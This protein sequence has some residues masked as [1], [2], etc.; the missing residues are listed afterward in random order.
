M[1]TLLLSFCRFHF[2][3]RGFSLF[4]ILGL[5]LALFP[6]QLHSWC[7]TYTSYSYI[8]PSTYWQYVSGSISPNGAYSYCFY[9][10]YG[11]TY[12][13]TFCS[14]SG[15]SATFDTYLC[16]Y[17]SSW[18]MITSNDDY[19]GLQSYIE[20]TCTGTG[21]YYIEV[22]GYGSSSG[23]YTLAYGY[24]G[25]S[26]H[27]YSCGIYDYG[28]YYPS[29]SWQTHSSS[30][31]ANGCR[32]Y[33]FYLYSGVPYTF[34][35][36]CG[37]GA[38][39]DFD[40]YLELYNSSCSL[41]ASNDDYCENLRSQ[42][43]YTPSV[44]GTYYLKV[45]GY[46][47]SSYGSY[48]LAYRYTPDYC[49]SCGTYDYGTFFPSSSWQT[50]SASFGYG[51]C[52]WYSFYL[53]AGAPYTFKTGCGDGA[54]ATFDTYLELYNSSCSMVASDDDACESFRSQINYTPTNSGYYYLKVRG[55]GSEGGSYTLA[56]KY[57]PDYCYSCGTYDYGTF[58]PS[59]SW[60]THSASLGYGGCRWYRFYLYSGTPYTFKT[61][62]GDGATADFD[63]YL[64]L[65][66]SS[67]SMVTSDDDACESLRSQISYTPSAS[68]YYYLKVR[69]YALAGGSYTLAYRQEM[70]PVTV[71]TSM[72]GGSVIVDGVTYASP[73]TVLWLS[74]SNHTI[75]VSSPQ[76]EGGGVR[77]VFSSWSDGGAQSH[78]IT[79]P[80]YAVTYTAYFTTQYQLTISAS[81]SSHDTP[82]P[83]I[84]TY[85]Y[86]AGTNI[87]ASVSS[88]TEESGGTRW[89]C[90]GYTGTGSVPSGSGSSLTF[91]IN[92]PSTLTWNWVR[93]HTL[94]IAGSPDQHGTSTPP[95]GTN[96]VDEGSITC[97][98]SS[99]ADESG[100]IRYRC[101]GYSGSFGSGSGNS[102]TVNITA[103]AS[104]TWNWVTQYRLQVSGSPEAHD[105]PS[106]P[107]GVSWYDAGT[108]ITASV[109]SP[110]DESGGIR[111]RCSGYTGSGSV[112]S[113]EG[114]RVDFTISSPSSITWNWITQYQFIVYNPGDY[115]TP[116]PAPGSYWYD[117]GSLINGSIS[118]PVSGES[119]VRYIC[120]GYTGTGSL[121]SVSTTSFS[122][123]ITQP[124]SVSWNWLTEY[125]LT[126]RTT[127]GIVSPADG[128]YRAGTTISI[129][130][131]PPESRQGERYIFSGWDGTGSGSYTGS[132][133]SATIT[134]NGPI[135]ESAS[136]LHQYRINVSGEP[137]NEDS[138]GPGYGENWFNEG[139]SVTAEVDS[140]VPVADGD[141]WRVVG[142]TGTGPVP[143]SGSSR[144]VTFTVTD[145]GSIV[146]HWL[147]EY[148]LVI[149]TPYG[150]P[151]PG[152]TTWQQA[153]TTVPIEI[154]YY[155]SG[156]DERHIF[157]GFIGSG[158]GSYTGSD[159]PATVIMNGPIVEQANFNYQ[160]RLIVNSSHGICDPPPGEHWYNYNTHI[161][162]YSTTRADSTEWR[163]Y[164][165]LGYTGA[166]SIP[167]SS[168][169]SLVCFEITSPS[170]ITWNWIAQFPFSIETDYSSPCPGIIGW[171]DSASVV[172][173][174]VVD[175]ILDYGDGFRRIFERWT[176]SAR[177][178]SSSRSNPV[179]MDS[180]KTARASWHDEFYLHLS[181]SGS[182]SAVPILSGEG[183]Y[184][185]G[186]YATISA[187]DVVW[188]GSIPYLF[189][190]WS[191]DGIILDSTSSGTGILID[192]VHYA[193][194]HYVIG[195]ARVIFETS[196]PGGNVTV[197][198]MTY[199]SPCTLEL[200]IGSSHTIEVDSIQNE[201]EITRYRFSGW[202]DGGER[203]HL[204]VISGERT[205]IANF[206]LQY[207]FEIANPELIGNP[208]P[209]SGIYWVD[210]GNV[211]VATIDRVDT[212]THRFCSGYFAT[213]SLSSG[214]TNWVSFVIIC[215]T[216]LEWQWSDMVRFEVVAPY[217]AARYVSPESLSW[218]IPGSTITASVRDTI[219][220]GMWTRHICA[221]FTGSGSVPLS[222][223]TNSV[224]FSISENSTLTWRFFDEFRLII[225]SEH[226]LATPPVGNYWYSSGVELTL[227]VTRIDNNW[228]CIGY[229]GSGDIGSGIDTSVTFV[230]TQPSQITWLWMERER[231][232]PLDIISA[233]GNPIPPVGRH[234]FIRGTNVTV[235]VEQVV[236]ESDGVRWLC[237]GF[238]GTGSV[239][240]FVGDTSYTFVIFDTTRIEWVWQKQYRFVVRSEHGTPTPRP[241]EY[242][243]NDGARV[244]GW[245][246]RRDD[247]WICTG[248]V[249]TGSLSS[250]LDTTFS[251]MIRAPSSVSWQ[252]S[253]ET[254][255]Y[256]L[257]IMPT[258]GI[259]HPSPGTY[260]LHAGALVYAYIENPVISMG[261]SQR[262]CYGYR[263]SG[264]VGEGEGSYITFVINSNTTLEWLWKIQ[265]RLS[266]SYTGTG[267][268]PVVQTG[269]GFYDPNSLVEI[270][271]QNYIEVSGVRYA[272]YNW[273]S[274]CRLEAEHPNWAS[275]R[276]LLS[277]PCQFVANYR[278]AVL[279]TLEKVP[280]QTWG[281][282]FV[283][284]REY[285]GRYR[286]EMWVALGSYHD[287][288][289][290]QYDTNGDERYA[291]LN[292]DD[293]GAIMHAIGPLTGNTYLR[294]NYVH[295]FSVE[296]RRAPAHDF[297]YL[298]IDRDIYER[299]A[300]SFQ[301]RWWDEG[302]IHSVQVSSVDSLLDTLY[303]FNSWSDGG[304]REHIVGP[305]VGPLRLYAYYDTYYK[306]IVRK[307]PMESY[308]WI[309][310]RGV[311]YPNECLV[312]LWVKRGESIEIGVSEF[313]AGRDSVYEFLRWND[314]G[315]RIHFTEPIEL[316][317]NF[318]AYYN[319]RFANVALCVSDTVINTEPIPLGYTF[320]PR[321]G[322]EITNC[323]DV[324][325]N[326][327][328]S[329]SVIDG[330]WQAG[331]FPGFDQ[332]V[333]RARFESSGSIPPAEF[334]PT[335]D[336]VKR[337]PTTATSSIFGPEGFNIP[338]CSLGRCNTY[339]WIQFLA[340][341]ASS[342]FE[343]QLIGLIITPSIALP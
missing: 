279:L 179:L 299:D 24:L 319:A 292:W 175:S 197:D 169:D 61:G 62:C 103:P 304:T 265:Y 290:S 206:V 177:G 115:D 293:G 270:S 133:V 22:A 311:R 254:T 159:N 307:E 300:S 262:V 218:W 137:T 268:N 234:Y 10:V 67:C 337:S 162:A 240:R 221:G 231:T 180:S 214:D 75:G 244:D 122:F 106:P 32:W 239:P 225:Q 27:C 23:S 320:V 208:L 146:W 79:V 257:T 313:D 134:M 194:A 107:Y 99:P 18:S 30:F 5:F 222:G 68:G 47:S 204:I 152:D 21:Y 81:P 111:Y 51:G 173:A 151:L 336:L 161:C 250:S 113:G 267:G 213:G 19:C 181:S 334:S 166:G 110:A 170:S 201:S 45:R 196:H 333:L 243:Y 241:G 16:L 74:G 202:S 25:G 63:T 338:P 101:T 140:I 120:T 130:A 308:G 155:P 148:R 153:G 26:E 249:G 216:Y 283:D 306:V 280:N 339:L 341:S 2:L 13:F 31:G 56:Y 102:V 203:S 294:A 331:Y 217:Y 264:S 145:S 86:N 212:T 245:V 17:N 123:A 271:T 168:S 301:T 324:M 211:V 178:F 172:Y 258:F 54:T 298:M 328:L 286:L 104:L 87:T 131:I 297:G 160:L 121:S 53:Y 144:S 340:P 154:V 60:Q 28:T 252:W 199:A 228:V 15:G 281:S 193:V 92:A 20:W 108:N 35:T 205:Y 49:Y 186:I 65:Y 36:G 97:T 12:I 207:T 150:T 274:D 312:S 263:G 256:T 176:G 119:G 143:S 41:V 187:E 132:S 322:I 85:W 282:I 237:T 318:I 147:H 8:Y 105:S 235:S 287:I 112:G 9:G 251:F 76:L 273:T 91:T 69:G 310:V 291:F 88:P 317:A 220:E 285:A 165:L 38:T 248:F 303:W 332:F 77:Y 171:Y 314:L 259:A 127:H 118:S 96:W 58:Y 190:H 135:S 305:V 223:S 129:S 29:S 227:S 296:I 57:T 276:V 200:V 90:S 128:W 278:G 184:P 272:F 289:V 98:V 157:N 93:Q 126:M 247:G 330:V 73:Y 210:S 84:G 138:P 230:L 14:Y 198:G 83:P 195:T 48:T 100:G 192:T 277:A 46:S 288:G 149:S 323:G 189:D 309:S 34:K 229:E 42:I 327:S 209:E 219:Y 139:A 6:A 255:A 269:A 1:R 233:L 66:N 33:A 185:R 326:L 164:V 163:R 335:R 266:L 316:P 44:S 182:G 117:S 70:I 59:S 40:T 80:T 11:Y 114:T 116:T 236:N 342:S 3:L 4:V 82:N 242:W 302:S 94:T 89:R 37:D 329:V 224:E 325:I 158:P 183:W 174:C 125:Y 275:T 109:S 167:E 72:P 315:E 215:P 232:V 191:S 124:S 64:E 226:G 43:S 136:W 7:Y 321:R 39:A 71:Q 188:D 246:A 238:N 156:E 142:F 50:H 284:G 343:R 141:R 260:Y 78:T 55:F 253:P 95:Y 295:Q 261:D 52:R